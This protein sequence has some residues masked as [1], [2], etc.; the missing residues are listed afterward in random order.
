MKVEKN[1]LSPIKTIV[2]SIPGSR[3]PGSSLR[4]GSFLRRTFPDRNAPSFVN[5]IKMATQRC[6][7]CLEDLES[8]QL[9]SFCDC[10][11]HNTCPECFK[12]YFTNFISN[13]TLGI[14]RPLLCPYGKDHHEGIKYFMIPYDKWESLCEREDLYKFD[15]LAETTLGFLCGRCHNTKSLLVPHSE[16]TR[17]QDFESCGVH[18]EYKDAVDSLLLKFSRG[19]VLAAT[20]WESFSQQYVPELLDVF[21]QQQRCSLLNAVAARIRNP[22]RRAALQISFYQTVSPMITTLCCGQDHCWKCK[23]QGAHPG[24][25][26]LL[27]L[28]C[29]H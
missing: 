11:A 7:I 20:V 2:R 25:C 3:I 5:L 13:Q 10:K 27:L 15:E 14:V 6:G 21:T 28:C 4:F 16:T 24:R 12:L 22:E 23:T 17:N 8:E 26:L 19:E 9:H 29:W 1:C 18:A